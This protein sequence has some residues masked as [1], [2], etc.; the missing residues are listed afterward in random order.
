MKSD[1]HA[2]WMEWGFRVFV[3][4]LLGLWLFVPTTGVPAPFLPVAK[5]VSVNDE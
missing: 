2:V 3:L 4:L 5:Q 1:R